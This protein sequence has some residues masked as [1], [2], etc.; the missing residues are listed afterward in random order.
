MLP[1]WPAFSWTWEELNDKLLDGGVPGVRYSE[2]SS[3]FPYYTANQTLTAPAP[4][5]A[6][7]MPADD[8]FEAIE[9]WRGSFALARLCIIPAQ[10]W[11]CV[12]ISPAIS[13]V[14]RLLYF[15]FYSP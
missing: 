8:F 15:L 10:L 12:C 3:M 13:F 11:R 1:Q 6:A 14:L 7:A 2:T 9:V 4:S 5:T